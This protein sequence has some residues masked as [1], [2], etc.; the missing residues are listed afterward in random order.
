MTTYSAEM[1]ES[2]DGRQIY[3][4]ITDMFGNTVKTNTVTLSAK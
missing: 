3:C 1:N 4:V 2:R